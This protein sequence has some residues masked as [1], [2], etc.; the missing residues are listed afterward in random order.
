MRLY[1]ME[2]YKLLYKKMFWISLAAVLGI[3]SAYFILVCVGEERTTIDGTLYT[4]LEAVSRNREITEEFKGVLTDEKAR[5]IIDTY[6]FPSQVEENYGGFRDENYLNGFVTE[7]LGNGYMRDWEDYQISTGLRPL[8]ETE[9]GKAAEASGRAVILDYAKGWTVFADLLQLGMILGSALVVAV[10]SPVFSEEHQTRMSALLFTSRNGR[11]KDTLA[12]IMAAFTAAVL[13]YI[14]IVSF[15]F[16]TVGAVYGFGGGKCMSGT[17]LISF[18]VTPSFPVTTMPAGA[19]VLLMLSLDLLAIFTI[20]ALTLCVSAHQKTA[21]HT[22]VLTLA[23][24]TA[25]LLLR[26]LFNGAGYLL[27]SGTPMF[28]VMTGILQDWYGMLFIPAGISACILVCA[29]L[30]G[31]NTWRKAEASV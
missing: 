20:C 22:V 5:R 12:K 2:L 18:Y 3:L 6:G 13:I 23:L 8:Q 1:K 19:I 9:L 4:G 31:W 27:A 15:L 28:L 7:Y 11:E 29:A 14:V 21:F 24:W 10:V 16:L 17:V 30:S 25:P 26:L